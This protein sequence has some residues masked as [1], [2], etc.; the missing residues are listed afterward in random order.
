MLNIWSE[1]TPGVHLGSIQARV[2]KRVT[3][4]NGAIPRAVDLPMYR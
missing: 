4:Y 3:P 1:T 2:L